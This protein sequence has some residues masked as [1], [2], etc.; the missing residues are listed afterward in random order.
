VLLGGIKRLVHQHLTVPLIFIAQALCSVDDK[1]IIKSKTH[2][3]S[4]GTVLTA[5][6]SPQHITVS[7]VL[8]AH[9]EIKLLIMRFTDS[10]LVKLGYHQHTSVLS[11]LIAQTP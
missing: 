11:I 3:R 1:Y 4:H 2:Q 6:E 5:L 10:E 8:M 9:E 7:S